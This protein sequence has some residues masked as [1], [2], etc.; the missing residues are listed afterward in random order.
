MGLCNET[1]RNVALN[2]LIKLWDRE[3]NQENRDILTKAI[4]IVL[5]H[6]FDKE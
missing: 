3:D 1:R 5:N 4:D 6:D 2:I